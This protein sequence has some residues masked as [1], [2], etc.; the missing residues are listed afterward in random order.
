LY[1]KAMVACTKAQKW[2]YAAKVL[3][4]VRLNG[5]IDKISSVIEFAKKTGA[6]PEHVAKLYDYAVKKKDLTIPSDL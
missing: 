4:H 6:S 2:Q 1:E 5:K 3:D